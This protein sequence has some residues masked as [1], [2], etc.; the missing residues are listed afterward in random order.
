MPFGH[1]TNAARSKRFLPEFF[2]AAA[3]MI[4]CFG[5]SIHSTCLPLW[6]SKILLTLTPSPTRCRSSL[7]SEPFSRSTVV[8][9]GV[10]LCVVTLLS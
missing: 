6:H 1:R 4:S 3:L 10:V 7:R 9:D 2:L 8:A 5:C